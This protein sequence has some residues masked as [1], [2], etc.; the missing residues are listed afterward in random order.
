M[1]SIVVAY[2]HWQSCTAIVGSRV[3]TVEQAFHKRYPVC[4]LRV[5]PYSVVVYSQRI[6]WIVAWL[7]VNLSSA[8]QRLVLLPRFEKKARY[9][10][11]ELSQVAVEV[12][13]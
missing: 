4:I 5:Y 8:Q 10:R 12:P 11:K 7:S 3:S 6:G 13:S 1:A 2:T 9:S